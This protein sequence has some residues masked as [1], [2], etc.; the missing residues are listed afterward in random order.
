[1]SPMPSRTGRRRRSISGGIALP[2]SP[3]SAASGESGIV[4]PVGS[5]GTVVGGAG[6]D[7]SGTRGGTVTGTDEATT[8]STWRTAADE[9][10]PGRSARNVM[11]AAAPSAAAENASNARLLVGGF[12]GVRALLFM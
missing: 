3:T 5:S 7:G 11:M 10:G 1:M 2:R 4:V 9:S 12:R 6:V 8:S